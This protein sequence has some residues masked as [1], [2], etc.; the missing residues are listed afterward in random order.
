MNYVDAKHIFIQAVRQILLA[1]ISIN[2]QH[3]KH[4]LNTGSR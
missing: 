2:I 3:F 4:S 1:C